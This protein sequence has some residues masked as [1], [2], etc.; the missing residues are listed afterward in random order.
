[1][2]ACSDVDAEHQ[3]DTG[4]RR[5]DTGTRGSELDGKRNEKADASSVRFMT[6]KSVKAPKGHWLAHI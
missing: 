4:T 5:A 2:R 1:V 6:R 3:A